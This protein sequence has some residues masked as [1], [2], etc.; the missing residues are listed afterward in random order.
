MWTMTMLSVG[1]SESFDGV[2]KPTDFR[3]QAGVEEVVLVP[4]EYN[5]AYAI[6]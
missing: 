3:P 4:A 1:W 6:C 5:G 2:W